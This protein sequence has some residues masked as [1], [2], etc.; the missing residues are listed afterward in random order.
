MNLKKATKKING[1]C[2][3]FL[4]K[5]LYI[6]PSN[7][8]H[9]SITKHILLVL[10]PL[11]FLVMSLVS[12]ENAG[13]YL[14]FFHCLSLAYKLCIIRY[15]RNN[16][17]SELSQQKNKANLG[18]I[19]TPYHQRFK[20]LSTILFI[21]ILIMLLALFHIIPI[22]ALYIIAVWLSIIVT[23]VQQVFDGLITIYHAEALKRII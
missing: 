13:I 21:L 1:F 17:D 4:K 10:M 14:F 22:D 2:V 16:L 6:V 19:I 5:R 23:F 9:Q 3:L 7:F 15:K 18:I 20:I 8:I 11:I 12:I